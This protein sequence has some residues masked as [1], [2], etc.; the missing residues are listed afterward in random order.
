MII[1]TKLLSNPINW[2]TVLL[3]LFIAGIFGHYLLYM[4]D[5]QPAV[6]AGLV[7][8][9]LSVNRLPSNNDQ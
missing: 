6:P 3:M 2:V 8:P 5:Q 7:T 4:F 9:S 1:N